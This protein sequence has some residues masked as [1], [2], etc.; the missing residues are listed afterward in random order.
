[1]VCRALCPRHPVRPSFRSSQAEPPADNRKTAE[2]YRAEGPLRGRAGFKVQSSREA[3]APN[4]GH[5]SLQRM[6]AGF[7]GESRWAAVNTAK[8]KPRSHTERLARQRE[9]AG[10][11]CG[12]EGYFVFAPVG[13]V[14]ATPS[15][16]WK[17]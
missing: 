11:T 13:Y 4:S 1:M 5:V 9:S 17:L 2:R 8:T 15:N 6:H 7:G 12:G 10:R 3:Q 14:G 16:F